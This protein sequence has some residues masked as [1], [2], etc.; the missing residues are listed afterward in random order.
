V[1]GMSVGCGAEVSE[2]ALAGGGGVEAK[3]HEESVKAGTEG[4]GTKGLGTRD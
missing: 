1:D 3:G 4:I 2:F